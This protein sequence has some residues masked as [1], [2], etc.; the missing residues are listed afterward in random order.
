MVVRNKVSARIFSLGT[1]F[2]TVISRETYYLGGISTGSPFFYELI[3]RTDSQKYGST[4]NN[5]YQ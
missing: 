1:S 5:Y 2:L 3:L 4:G